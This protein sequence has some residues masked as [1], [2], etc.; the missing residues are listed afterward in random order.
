MGDARSIQDRGPWDPILSSGR[1]RDD[2]LNS[3]L[4]HAGTVHQERLA[5][6]TEAATIRRKT[7]RSPRNRVP[8]SAP[9]RTE[10]S[11]SAAIRDQRQ[12]MDGNP[13]RY[14]GDNAARYIPPVIGRKCAHFVPGHKTTTSESH[15]PSSTPKPSDIGNSLQQCRTRGSHA[16]PVDDDVTCEADAAKCGKLGCSPIPGRPW[17]AP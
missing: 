15:G 16:E 8:T 12:G 5:R 11:R 1:D 9:K 4:D 14:R 10:E 6:M 13:V 7:N 17:S 2:F 3:L